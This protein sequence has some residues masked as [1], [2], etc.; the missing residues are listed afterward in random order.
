[1][2]KQMATR[3]GLMAWEDDLTG[4]RSKMD[5]V[6]KA[7]QQDVKA[8]DARTLRNA[9]LASLQ[10]VLAEKRETYFPLSSVLSELASIRDILEELLK[11][12][13]DAGVSNI[14]YYRYSRN[15]GNGSYLLV[16]SAGYDEAFADR[17]SVGEVVRFEASCPLNSSDSFWAHDLTVPVAVSV[18]SDASR[19]LEPYYYPGCLPLLRIPR[20][21]CE[22]SLAGMKSSTWVDVPV[23][24]CGQLT[25]KLSCDLEYSSAQLRE[26]HEALLEFWALAQV[27][28]PFF[29]VLYQR[30]LIQPLTGVLESVQ[31]CDSLDELFDYCT[32]RLPGFFD[33]LNAS[34]FA[35]SED[36]FGSKKL[37]LE[38]TSF[39]TAR[40]YEGQ[41]KYDLSDSALTAWVARNNR[42]LRLHNLGIERDREQ[43]LEQYR[44]F[45]KRLYWEDRITDSSSHASFLAVP[46]PGET[47][48]VGGVIRFTEKSTA[49]GNH[50]FTQQDQAML[51]RVAFDAIG[52]RLASLRASSSSVMT[53]DCV[54]DA[55]R[56]MV[57][58]R[59]PT[60]KAIATAINNMLESVF[61]SGSSKKLFLLN[62]L[63]NDCEHFQHFK[64]GGGLADDLGEGVV[65]GLSGSLTNYVVDAFLKHSRDPLF[66]RTVFVND[67]PNAQEADAM[68]VIC[69]QAETALACPV[70]FRDKIYGVI[71]VKSDSHDIYPGQHCYPL[72][73]VAAQAGSMFARRDHV[74]LGL[75]RAHSESVPRADLGDWLTAV[76]KM[77]SSSGSDA[78]R[79]TPLE[80]VNLKKMVSDVLND[81]GCKSPRIEVPDVN[82]CVHQRPLIAVMYGVLKDIC[83]ESCEP[84]QITGQV[85]DNWLELTIES[86]FAVAD[87]LDGEMWM[88]EDAD[89]IL[90]SKR[91]DLI[92][93]LRKI[94]YFNQIDSRWGSINQNESDLVLKF[95]QAR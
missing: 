52:R 44:V 95:P 1:M 35:V 59:T 51:E 17:L 43:Q 83:V 90:N 38:R 61:P 66:D 22:E 34:I 79:T 13:S 73:L 91:G 7:H 77:F 89:A 23:A 84:V 33:C 86:F 14:R 78:V 65:Y 19:W 30:Q 2:T 31:G 15:H 63:T 46:I 47:G 6:S 64:I 67:L 87:P 25:G 42:P 69:K 60:T 80:T 53:Y 62:V 27:A 40:Q 28:A 70:S 92:T 39:E 8:Q 48:N 26:H 54:Q 4:L 50:H 55:N 74:H 37:V 81:A 56:V 36:T 72:E 29:D 45:D 41:A 5:L 20:D 18:D 75:L 85:K 12:S 94:T 10:T 58:E 82:V 32:A 21:T 9:T 24:I 88:E 71:I 76:E 57:S 49:S 16:D 93:L 3:I 11:L 68:L